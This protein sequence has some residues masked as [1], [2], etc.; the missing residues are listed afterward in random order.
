MAMARSP[1]LSLALVAILGLRLLAPTFVSTGFQAS[2]TARA[3]RGGSTALRAE[4]D[5]SAFLKTLKVEQDIELSPEEYNMALEQE[6]EAQRRKYYIGGVVKKQNLVVPWKPVDEK[7]LEKDARK[8]LR[9][10]GIKDPSGADEDD[11]IEED[12][13]VDIAQVGENIRLDWAGGAPSTKVG[14]VV[15]RK[16]EGAANFREIATYDNMQTPTLLAKQFA[17]HEYSYMDDDVPAGTYTYRVLCRYR[18]GEIT[19][20]DEKEILVAEPPGADIKY[21]FGALAGFV[22]FTGFFGFTMDPGVQ[23]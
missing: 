4:D 17:G 16:K 22:F 19:V 18:S 7:V 2:S 8:Q 13:E 10:N 20:V 14:Y 1:L 6:V 15:E 21:S 23:P 12:S 9:K 3:M 11:E 5:G